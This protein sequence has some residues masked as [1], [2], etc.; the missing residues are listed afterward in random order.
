MLV[1]NILDYGHVKSS[2]NSCLD[3]NFVFAHSLY[4]KMKIKKHIFLLKIAN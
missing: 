4:K 1:A 3:K 2:L